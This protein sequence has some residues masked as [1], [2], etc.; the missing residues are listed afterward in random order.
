[1]LGDKAPLR[2]HRRGQEEARRLPAGRRGALVRRVRRQRP[3]RRRGR[4]R[5]ARH[6]LHLPAPSARAW[7]RLAASRVSDHPSFDLLRVC[8]RPYMFTASPGPATI[9]TV[10]AALR[11]IAEEPQLRE[12]HLGQRQ[13]ALCG[14]DRARPQGRRRDEPDH[15]RPAARRGDHGLGLEPAAASSASTSTWRCRPAR[16]TASACCAA[17]CRQRTRPQQ[18]EQVV[19]RFGVL[20]REMPTLAETA[21][22]A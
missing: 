22:V 6:R 5:R 10:R 13:G 18:I 19:S 1:M 4:R 21:A 20:A 12:Q 14:P 7:A 2:E 17:R 9:A 11:R 3:R 8:A 16:P 15:R